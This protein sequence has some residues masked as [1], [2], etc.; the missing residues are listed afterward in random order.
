MNTKARSTQFTFIQKSDI[1]NL[2]SSIM[3]ILENYFNSNNSIRKQIW[4]IG[5]LIVRNLL[6]SS[7]TAEAYDCWYLP[8]SIEKHNNKKGGYCA[9]MSPKK[10]PS[11][12]VSALDNTEGKGDAG[13]KSK[14]QDNIQG[15]QVLEHKGKITKIRTATCYKEFL[16]AA[17]GKSSL[18]YPDFFV[19]WG[20]W[21]K[22]R[23]ANFI[24]FAWALGG[25][26]WCFICVPCIL[27]PPFLVHHCSLSLSTLAYRELKNKLIAP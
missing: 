13:M 12:N 21:E 6:N 24:W 17:G 10:H 1:S 2:R 7:I 15:Q 25:L 16:S 3:H 23:I 22:H 20:F 19:S 5:E 14:A 26:V 18:S 27:Y 4:S 11:V 9:T 8:R